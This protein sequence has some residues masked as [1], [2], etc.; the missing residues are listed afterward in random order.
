VQFLCNELIF[1]QE[2]IDQSVFL[3]RELAKALS[4]DRYMPMA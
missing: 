3:G 4:D 1:S 2:E